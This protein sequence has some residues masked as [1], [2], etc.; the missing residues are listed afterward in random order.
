MSMKKKL[1]EALENSEFKIVPYEQFLDEDKIELYAC[2]YCGKDDCCPEG[3]E[4]CDECLEDEES[5]E[6]FD[7][8]DEIKRSQGML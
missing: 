5:D 3:Q 2:D 7:I 4:L 8:D 6:Y 1:Y